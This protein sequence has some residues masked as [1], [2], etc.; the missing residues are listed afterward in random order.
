MSDPVRGEHDGPM[1]HIMRW[2]RPELVVLLLSQE[3]YNHEK[4][5]ER[6]EKTKAW[7]YNHW[8]GYRPDFRYIECDVRSAHDIDA[9]DKPLHDAFSSLT[10]ESPDAEILINLTSGTPQMQ[11]ILSQLA[12][13]MRYR[14]RGIQVINFEYGSGTLPRAND[15]QY[16]VELELECNEDEKPEAENRCTEPA[17]YAM[18]KEY[19]RRQVVALLEERDF[20]AIEKLKDSLPEKLRHLAMHLAERNRL[21]GYEAKRLAGGIKDL[22]FELYPFKK[23]ERSEY[24]KV[25]EYYL[26]MKNLLKTGNCTEFL[27]HLEPL[28]LN[29]QLAMLD[30]MLECTGYMTKTGEFICRE[31]Q[32]VYFYPDKLLS[33]LPDLY[34]HYAQ[35]MTAKGKSVEKKEINTFICENLLSFFPGVPEK[36]GKLFS[37]YWMLKDLRNQLAHELCLVTEADI[38]AACQTDPLKLLEEMEAT[39]IA[40]YPA[41]DPV[42][43]SVYEKSMD[44][45]KDNL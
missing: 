37:H 38:R 1:L 19:L 21:H 4:K 24:S 28:T 15:P 17:M 14:T 33:V 11:M 8:E 3:I 12:M 36:A 34:R 41:C 45:I 35:Q 20:G 31:K 44:Y 42:V 40:C 10:T 16:D 30:R 32:R 18:Q 13:D 2:Y 5:D 9:L 25:C 27:L 23:G 7:I 43:F 39:I 29:L 22:P 6:F 26:T